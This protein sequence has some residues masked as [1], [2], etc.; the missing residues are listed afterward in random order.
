M[1]I[2]QSEFNGVPFRPTSVEPGWRGI[3]VAGAGGCEG[4]RAGNACGDPGSSVYAGAGID[5]H[6]RRVAAAGEAWSMLLE[7]SGVESFLPNS[8]LGWL[9]ARP[10]GCQRREDC[11]SITFS[12]VNSATRPDAAVQLWL[13]CQCGRCSVRELNGSL[14]VKGARFL[15]NTI[16]SYCYQK[17]NHQKGGNPAKNRVTPRFL[18]RGTTIVVSL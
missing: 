7:M 4:S 2:L 16:F 13:R 5:R 14:G 10:A 11:I 3:P 15:I 18:P 9:G 1:A 8:N 12:L 17:I 6:C